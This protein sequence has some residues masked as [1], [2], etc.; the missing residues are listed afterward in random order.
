MKYNGGIGMWL[1]ISL[2]AENSS[3]DTVIIRMHSSDS[4]H[5]GGTYIYIYM[6]N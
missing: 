3:K 4:V 1:L 5:D 6:Y 2:C